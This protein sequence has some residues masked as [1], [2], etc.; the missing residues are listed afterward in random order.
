MGNDHTEG[1]HMSIESSRQK[2]YSLPLRV[3]R[4]DLDHLPPLEQAYAR[5]LIETR[6]GE[7]FI[8]VDDSI[9]G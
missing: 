1:D 5:Y 9:G 6:P 8:V 4:E 7:V 3:S 2:I